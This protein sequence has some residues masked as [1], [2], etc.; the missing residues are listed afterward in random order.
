MLPCPGKKTSIYK[1]AEKRG[2]ARQLLGHA[3][4]FHLDGELLGMP[5]H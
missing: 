4:I 5:P 3:V 2:C 1:S